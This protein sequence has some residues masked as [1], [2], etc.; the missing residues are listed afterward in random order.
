V[1]RIT[2]QPSLADERSVRMNLKVKVKINLPKEHVKYSVEKKKT[3][4]FNVKMN[5]KQKQ[6]TPALVRQKD[7]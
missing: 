2:E 6:K 1:V 7:K 5:L 4:R 3:Q